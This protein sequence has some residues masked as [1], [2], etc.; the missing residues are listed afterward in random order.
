M[1]ESWTVVRTLV[2]VET[3]YDSHVKQSEP[4]TQTVIKTEGLFVYLFFFSLF[5]SFSQP[6]NPKRQKLLVFSEDFWLIQEV[7]CRRDGF[8]IGLS[9]TVLLISRNHH[10]VNGPICWYRLA[11]FFS[12]I[13]ILLCP[14]FNWISD[15]NHDICLFSDFWAKEE[16]RRTMVSCCMYFFLLL[17]LISLTIKANSFTAAVCP[18][19]CT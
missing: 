9:N 16:Q 19:V 3:N 4:Q 18:L 2:S 1:S 14:W 7:L 8:S 13:N 11:Y 15:C 12:C 6:G 17:L 5:P 10:K